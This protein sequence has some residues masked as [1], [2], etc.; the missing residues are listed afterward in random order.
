MIPIAGPSVLHLRNAGRRQ[1]VL[2]AVSRA[3]TGATDEFSGD[4]GSHSDD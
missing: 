3:R 2:V 1:L 4:A